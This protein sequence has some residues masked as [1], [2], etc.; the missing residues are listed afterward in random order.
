MSSTDLL[1][2]ETALHLVRA[3]FVAQGTSFSKWCAQH[4]ITRSWAINTIIG[5][6]NGPTALK[7]RAHII[8]AAI[9]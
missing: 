2:S 7:L 9:P 3:G 8:K 6:R 1:P 5:K 4:G